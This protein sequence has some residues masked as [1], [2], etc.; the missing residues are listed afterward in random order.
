MPSYDIGTA[1][2][3]SNTSIA[4][5]IKKA[6]DLGEMAYCSYSMNTPIALTPTLTKVTGWVSN[7]APIKV[8]EVSGVFTTSFDAVTKFD[9]E[10]IYQHNDTNP[11]NP[12]LLR[13]QVRKNGIVF[14]DRTA[15][16]AAAT[17]ADEPAILS[18][19]TPILVENN[20]GDYY[21]IY[22]SA[23][24]GGGQPDDVQLVRMN[25]VAHTIAII[26]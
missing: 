7:I 6:N 23:D 20:N 14:I 21:E 1:T 19:T 18:Y 8:S 24:E 16:I 12:A 17:A 13:I 25:L 15:N 26:T 3:L 22:V 4:D 9:L 5:A 10:R 11:N 2:G